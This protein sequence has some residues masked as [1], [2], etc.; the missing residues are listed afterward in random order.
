MTYRA[1][2]AAQ[3]VDTLVPH[4]SIGSPR[5]NVLDSDL[6]AGDV[7][8]VGVL[9]RLGVGVAGWIRS[10]LHWSIALSFTRIGRIFDGWCST[11]SDGE[12]LKAQ[13]NTDSALA[14]AS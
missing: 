12:R 10:Q 9:A 8:V 1:S 2:V 4:G 5:L 11:L 13:Q 14:R 6:L 7:A 3:S